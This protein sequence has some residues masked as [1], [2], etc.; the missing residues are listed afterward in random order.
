VS[1][2]RGQAGI[3][4]KRR[5]NSAPKREKRKVARLLADVAQL[6]GAVQAST[7]HF[8]EGDSPDAKSVPASGP[9][10]WP[11]ALMKSAAELERR[12]VALRQQEDYVNEETAAMAR[13]SKSLPQQLSGLAGRK[14]SAS[15]KNRRDSSRNGTNGRMCDQA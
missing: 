10:R 2:K 8:A 13:H 5:Q 12:E 1:A 6:R 9:K 15:K 7:T 4:L 11:S 14:K 3:K